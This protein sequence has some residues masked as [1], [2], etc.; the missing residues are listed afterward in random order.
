MLLQGRPDEFDLSTPFHDHEN[1]LAAGGRLDEIQAG[2]TSSAGLHQVH[3]WDQ[4]DG[5]GKLVSPF[6]HR[7][8]MEKPPI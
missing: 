3:C 2:S 4:G 8:P 5:V 1:L 7:F 6:L